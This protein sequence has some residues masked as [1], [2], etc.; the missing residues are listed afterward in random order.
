VAR[1]TVT[2]T[3]MGIPD[4]ECGRLFERFF[5]TSSAMSAAVPGTGLGLTIVQAIAESHDGS[6][7]VTSRVREGTTF[8]VELPIGV[9]EPA[10]A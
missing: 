6:V 4:E 1:I 7:S 9:R 8:V 2:D 3:G 10:T 5:R